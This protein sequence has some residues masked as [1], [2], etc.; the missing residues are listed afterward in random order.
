[1]SKMQYSLG[2]MSDL[3]ALKPHMSKGDFDKYTKINHSITMLSV[4]GYIPQ[5]VRNKAY[6]KLSKAINKTVEQAR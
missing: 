5:S 3:S 4:H 2:G 1:M 6:D